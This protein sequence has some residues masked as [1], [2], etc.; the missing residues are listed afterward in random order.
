[1]ADERTGSEG[2][3]RRVRTVRKLAGLTQEQLANKA[4]VS[5]SLV[6]HVEQGRIPASP[7]FV[8][9]TARALRVSVPELYHD[10]TPRLGTERAGVAELETTIMAGF[11]PPD[12]P[13]D[14]GTLTL[15]SLAARVGEVA[16]LQ[17]H[18]RYE[19]SSEQLPT[20]I[21][22]LRALTADRPDERVHRLLSRAYGIAAIALHR[23]GS[24]VAEQA[25]ERAAT[26]A[27]HSGDPLLAA[28]ADVEV[29]YRL[30]HRGAY[31]AAD[32]LAARARDSV[33]DLPVTVDSLSVRGYSHLSAAIAA[34]RAGDADGSTDHL[35]AAGEYAAHV[36]DGSDRYDTAF[37]PSNVIMHAVSAAVEMGDGTT[38]IGRNA[39]VQAAMPSR[40]AHHH[41][42]LA[43]AY[44]LHGDR[45]STLTELHAARAAAPTLTR[46]HPMVSETVRVL[47]ETDRRRTA[48]LAEFA[49]WAGIAV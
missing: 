26:T 10:S 40:R 16:E 25:G 13:D 7:A 14:P 21:D 31:R 44:L 47:A 33:A 27:R 39:P 17:R 20:L 46:Y 30:L 34:A 1:M 5:A 42:D 9:A 48:G 8:A 49:V 6:R 43:R 18:G 35:R 3:G 4:H 28:A 12:T 32:R 36:P 11:A 24:T 15:D 41:V 45:G 22:D 37:S 29:G 38:A 19:V 23:L 2:V